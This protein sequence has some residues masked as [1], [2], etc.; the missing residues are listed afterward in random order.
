MATLYELT[1]EYQALL[2]LAEDPDTDADT[3]ADTF[4]GLDGEIEDKAEGYAKVM[5][6]IA[7]DE[8]EVSEEIKRLQERKK[9]LDQHVQAMKSA[10]QAAMM[11]TGKRKFKTPLFSFSVQKNPAHVV[12]DEADTSKIPIEYLKM[13]PVV[14]KEKIK[15]DLKN[16]AEFTF[17]HLEQDESLRIR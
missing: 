2:A 15:T 10:L 6:Q 4:E 13:D 11:A 9:K 12:L 5:R 14:D 17:A 3:L 1:E 8:E 7:S 16:G